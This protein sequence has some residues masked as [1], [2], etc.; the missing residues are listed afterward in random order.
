MLFSIAV[1]MTIPL[2]L[3]EVSVFLLSIGM[4]REWH[5]PNML[6]LVRMFGQACE[7]FSTEPGTHMCTCQI[8]KLRLRKISQQNVLEWR[9]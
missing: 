3:H 4:E 1:P 2:M 7:M 9:S 5:L 8:L 6:T